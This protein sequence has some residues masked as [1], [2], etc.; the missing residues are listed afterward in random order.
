MQL[1]IKNMVCG[2]CI[3]VVGEELETLGYHVKQ[4]SLGE[5]EI[6]ETPD[7]KDLDSIRRMLEKNGFELLDD[8][9][10]M[11]VTQIKSIIIDL[12]H[13][14]PEDYPQQNYSE[15]IAHKLHKDYSYLSKLFSS[16]ENI[17][18][19]KYIILQK[20]ERVKELL[21]YD[22]LTLS[23]IA[24]ELGYSSVQHLSNQFKKTTGLSPSAFKHTAGNKR[25]P[26]DEV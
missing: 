24:Y 7:K 26:L 14:H 8:K 15:I 22:E 3:K 6:A 18:I 19:E 5:V 16:V 12:I 25:K 17:T 2:R 9:N 23:E 13:H 10:A 1:I 4:I 21:V 20:I 11:L